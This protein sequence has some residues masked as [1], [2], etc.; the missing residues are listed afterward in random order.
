MAGVR[1]LATTRRFGERD[2]L[3]TANLIDAD[4]RRR[5]AAAVRDG[6][7]LCL[8][9]PL[10]PHQSVSGRPGMAMT[11]YFQHVGSS[12]V[13]FDHVELD[14]HGFLSTHLDAL[15]HIGLDGSLYSGWTP[16]EHEALAVEGR[17]PRTGHA[18]RGGGHPGA[19]RHR[20]GG[21]SRARE[22][23]RSRGGARRR[24]RARRARRRAAHLHG[25]GPVRV[26]GGRLRHLDGLGGSRT[27]PGLGRRRVARRP[28]DLDAGVGLPRRRAPVGA[29]A[30]RPLAD[31][32]DR[33]AHRRQLRLLHGGA[34]VAGTWR[35][36]RAC[37]RSD[38]CR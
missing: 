4:A 13:G 1:E 23:R 10:V 7:A 11:P 3:G 37:S 9:R 34:G 27:G 30:R 18:W 14:C 5:G 15:N 12:I 31:L 2:R 36:T 19:A 25:P 17:P 22:R 26:I 38:R 33:A 24:R 32:G 8:A 20:L 21:S 16:D 28:P 35:C 6:T 29:G